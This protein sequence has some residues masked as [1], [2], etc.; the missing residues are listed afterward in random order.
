MALQNAAHGCYIGNVFLGA[1]AYVDDIAITAPTP[2]GNA[3]NA[4]VV[5]QFCK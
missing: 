1:L 2:A 5:R 3:S 4:Q